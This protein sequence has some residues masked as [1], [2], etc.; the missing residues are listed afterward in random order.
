MFFIKLFS[1]GNLLLFN[2]SILQGDETCLNA[3]IWMQTNDMQSLM[4]QLFFMFI[5]IFIEIDI[6]FFLH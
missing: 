1:T 6:K 4:I 3:E 5:V 2:P